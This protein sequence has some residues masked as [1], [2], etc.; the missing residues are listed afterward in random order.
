MHAVDLHIAER[1]KLA[2]TS[3]GAGMGKSDG[4]SPVVQRRRLRGEL[5]RIRQEANETQDQ[6]AAVMDWSLSKLIRIENG[7]VGISTNDL[8]MLLNHYG[9]TDD[10]RVDELVALAKA[11]KERSWWSVYGD[12]APPRLIQF[13]EYESAAIVRRSFEPLLI[14]GLLQTEE[15]AR[16]VI[17]QFNGR[18]PK[19][20]L[21]ALVAFRM[22]RQELLKRTVPPPW[23]FFILNEGV[24]RRVVGGNDIMQGQIRHL[25]E[26]A[27]QKNVTIEIVPFT[28]GVHRGMHGPF[29]VLEFPEA[30]D[31]DVLYLESPRG[32]LINRDDPEEILAYREIFED[33]RG[34]SLGEGSVEFLRG[35]LDE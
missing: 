25:I 6:V 22:K 4:P 19:D 15:Y 32:D 1:H 31:D 3:R 12:I 8:K 29:V 20:R 18:P 26:L 34:M 2:A 21:D 13:I 28:A 33:L 7:S 30:E 10:N 35:L 9:I 16:E 23:F 14:P 5:R 27:S 11:A 17:R 24:V